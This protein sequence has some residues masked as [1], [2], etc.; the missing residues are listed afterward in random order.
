MKTLLI[1]IGNPGRR[2]DGLGPALVERLAGTQPPERALVFLERET[3]PGISISPTAS[4]P[5]SLSQRGDIPSP[6]IKETSP[7]ASPCEHFPPSAGAV[8]L[9]WVYQLNIEDAA[10]VRDYDRVIFAD[11]AGGETETGVSGEGER[12]ESASRS[13]E[14]GS[15][16]APPYAVLE[17]L[18]PAASIAFT[19]HELS[20]ASVLALAEEL[21]GKAPAGFLL[22]VRGTEWDFAEGLSAEGERGL[23]EAERRLREFLPVSP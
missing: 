2:D 19:T 10:A 15:P 3:D 21:Y 4:I 20:P 1:G 11:A 9:F 13:G 17:S 12:D 23:A 18:P 5:G 8:G 22:K 16:E 7:S 14:D 6:A